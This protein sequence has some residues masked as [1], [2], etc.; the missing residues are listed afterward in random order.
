MRK[1]V[2]SL[3]AIA[4]MAA[5]GSAAAQPPSGQ[6]FILHQEQAKPSQ[7][8]LYEETAK[9]FKE[10]VE[11]N[12]AAMPTFYF[13]V[14]Q[15][16]DL[17][18]TYAARIKN[19]AG[20]DTINAEFGALF[21][22]AGDK[23]AALM[24]RGGPAMDHFAE[25]VVGEEPGMGYHPAN[26]K[27]KIEDARYRRYT[28]YYV[29][30]G[31][32]EEAKAIAADFVA[33]FKSKNVGNGYNLYWAVTGPDLPLLVV[34]Q[35]AKDEADYLATDAAVNAAVGDAIKPLNQRALA[36]TRRMETKS[37]WLRPDLSSWPAEP[38]KK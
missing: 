9:E 4:L 3:A 5:A 36:I 16:D 15:G 10:L 26:P 14:L 19:F 13:T 27:L 30:P 1:L 37:A 32:E 23:M 29:M 8:A 6:W 34:E 12:R 18:Y 38:A 24:Q 20:I 7:V 28:L 33:L 25:F 2:W 11:A 35:W 21:Q 17:T 31:K 22:A